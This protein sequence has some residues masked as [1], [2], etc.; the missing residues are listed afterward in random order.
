MARA[1]PN[2]DASDLAQ[3]PHP[4]EWQALRGELVALLD[5]VEGRY[6][7]VERGEPA[8]NGITRRVRNLRDQ[9]IG[10][11]PAV[12]R[13]E[14]LQ[15]VKRAVDRFSERD[16]EVQ[17]EPERDA[18]S[19]A[20]A[21]IR[22]RQMSAPAAALGRRASD[23]PE[24]RE[25]TSLVSGLSG[26]LERLEGELKLQRANNGSV[27]EVAS[28]V[29][30]LTHVVELLAGAVGET[31]QVKRLES[32][33]GALAALIEGGPKVDLSAL[34]KRLDDVSTTVGKLAELQ[35]QQMER[36]I[37]REDRR[38]KSPDT[39]APAMHA[40]EAS[41]RNV[42]D[43]IDSIERNVTL[44][45]GDFERLTAEMAAF[46]QVMK[47]S[48][49]APGRL[50]AK[51]DALAARIGGF[52]NSNGDVAGLKQD[53]ASLRDAVMA[54]MEPRFLRIES[55][56]EALSDRMPGDTGQV[57]NQLKLLMARMDEAGDQLNGLAKLYSAN[58]P[59]AAG[60]EA[61]ATLVAERTS[62]AISRK[63]PAPVAM[64]G[65]DSL[66][67]IEDR[68]TGLIKS[69]GKTPDYEALADLVAE[70][71]S[72]AFARST[73]PA[74]AA[75][76]SE[77]SMGQFEK[78]MSALFNTAGKD[79][80]ERLTRL[81]AV[82]T[83]AQA[84]R[85]AAPAPV[86]A[87]R[88]AAVAPKTP[89][90]DAVL[91]ALSQ[92]EDPVN[93]RFDAM[94]SALSGPRAP[95]KSDIMP[96]NP[97]DDAPLVDPGFKDQGPV[98]SALEAKVGIRPR[99]PVVEQPVAPRPAATTPAFD[100]TT[101]ERPPRPQSSFA[102]AESDPFAALAAPAVPS[103]EAPASASSTSTF[104]AAARRAQRA[105][106]DATAPAAASSNSLIGRALSR[107][108]PAQAAAAPAVDTADIAEPKLEKP[109]KAPKPVKQKKEK[110]APVAPA[111][112]DADVD[113][114]VAGQSFLARHRR[115]LLLAAVL[116]AVSMLAL[117]LVIQRSGGD[118]P[119]PDVAPPAAETP[120]APAGDDVSLVRPEPRIIDM[121]DGTATGSI[122]P[123][124]QMSFTKPVTAT[125]MP[126]T[127]M[128]A[129]TG[130]AA[131]TP[132]DVPAETMPEV[133]GSIS[134]A[135]A[136]VT[137]DLPAEAVGPL[138][139]RQAAA[140]GDA[141]AQFEIGAIYTEGR[142]IPQDYA[143]AG[144]WYERSAAQGFVPA[145]YR[146]GN[147]FEAGQG[148][149][150]D[151]EVAK[152][153][154]QRAAEAGNRM[155]MHNLAALYAGGL[156][157]DQEF[158]TAA[159]WFAQAAAKG[160]TDSQFNLGMLFARGLGVEQDFAQSYKWFS[161]AA[162]NGDKDAAQA[163]DDMAKSLTAEQ[164]S[165]VTAE[166]NGWKPEALDL[167]TNF[168]P[169]GTWSKTFDPGEVITTRDVVSKVQLVLNKLGFDVG[170]ADGVAGPK[171]AE[172]IKAF[173]RGTG[174][175]ESGTINPRLLAVLGSQPV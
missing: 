14:A 146:L 141:K 29:E 173:E 8:L 2:P 88:A 9:V 72:E 47:D 132:V 158:E 10:P 45:S 80:A 89:T 55:Q 42:Y 152:L 148:V 5:Q 50:V 131:I 134:A 170:T 15:T 56:I 101:A 6:A 111:F 94:L 121:I 3:E 18:L 171:T 150:K 113:A 135:T 31:G 166:V 118:T 48:D 57:E 74:P 153:W 154:Y 98:R 157:G 125:P 4:G 11:E 174:M 32:Q 20:I 119:A 59:D 67:S 99:P 37:A 142:A 43:R 136:P 129:N 143:E 149:E 100:P 104:V 21:E 90:D 110:P 96:T 13:R 44:S 126:P 22:G 151:I 93:D 95:A 115:P 79:T 168:A 128:A 69:A 16:D 49:V 116:V 71:T 82:L 61:M 140:N 60:M 34:N 161:L 53:I 52:E 73:P 85:Q 62:D 83:A 39:I 46:T 160:M 138:E 159:E 124:A 86:T 75:G 112:G 33:I 65:A 172:A 51:V 91:Q 114:S 106:Q 123:N 12:R 117:N 77:E 40:I 68:I 133:T 24:F 70:R 147:L 102:K 175:S 27:S 105:R 36:E 64:F 167:A 1:Y 156:L 41:V 28:Q 7:D 145:Q 17:H 120:T 30:Q 163:R 97:G 84:E 127:L 92:D 130:R 58:Q 19:N 78:R 169:L 103:V 35:A 81:E 54:S 107:V 66:K 144:K 38:A 139:L 137:F 76:I 108:M 26:R 63:A 23:Q 162:R 25:L 122:N 164:V 165:T 87:P 109:A 155:A